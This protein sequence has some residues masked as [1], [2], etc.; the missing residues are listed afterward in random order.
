MLSKCTC[1]RVLTSSR[2]GV[3]FAHIKMKVH[4]ASGGL[5]NY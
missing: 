5:E 3:N 2:L 4:D 1:Y